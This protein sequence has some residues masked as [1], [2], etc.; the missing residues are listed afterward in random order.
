VKRTDNVG[1]SSLLFARILRLTGAGLF[2]S[3]IVLAEFAYLLS[4]SNPSPELGRT[5]VIIIVVSLVSFALG[6]PLAL[7]GDYISPPDPWL[8]L[9]L[10]PWRFRKSLKPVMDNESIE[11]D[12][13]IWATITSDNDRGRLGV[14]GK[15]MV[16]FEPSHLVL[17]QPGKDIVMI[18]PKKVLRTSKLTVLL[19]TGAIGY[20]KVTATFNSASDADTVER[21]ATKLVEHN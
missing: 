15:C 2:V 9:W 11:K 5:F 13:G 16:K 18:D 3:F 1:H 4:F 10:N 21:E 17:D 19:D 14:K 6:V 8:D 20:G 12:E 7:I